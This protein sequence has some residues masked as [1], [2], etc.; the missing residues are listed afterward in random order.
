MENTVTLKIEDYEA[1]KNEIRD[2]ESSIE[3]LSDERITTSIQYP[4]KGSYS[5]VYEGDDKAIQLVIKQHDEIELK[6]A[7]LL[8]IFNILSKSL[9]FKLLFKKYINEAK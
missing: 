9:L 8:Q 1:L 5:I 4:W 6:Y 2:L 7:K 3:V